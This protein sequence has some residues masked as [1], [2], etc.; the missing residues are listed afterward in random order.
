[1]SPASGFRTIF[2]RTIQPFRKMDLQ[3]CKSMESGVS[4]IVM[5][6]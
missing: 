3:V 2:S 1:M 6:K 4:V 5:V